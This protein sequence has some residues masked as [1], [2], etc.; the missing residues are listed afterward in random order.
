M[1]R[2]NLAMLIVFGPATIFLAESI[3]ALT[4]SISF[5][6]DVLHLL[7]P[8]LKTLSDYCSSSSCLFEP[9]LIASTY[10]LQ[11]VTFILLSIVFYVS[12]RT[13]K[14]KLDTSVVSVCGIVIAGI[15]IDYTIGNF[16]FRPI[17]I[18]PNSV[19]TSP[20][21]LFRYAV[22]FSIASICAA[23]LTNVVK[24]EASDANS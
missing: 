12:G 13:N 7:Y 8:P 5:P 1:K 21:G 11:L 17:W 2:S 18:A 23:T 16:S 20:L 4:V 19:A 10:S 14:Y 6:D 15:L 9:Q 24:K 3:A 22:M